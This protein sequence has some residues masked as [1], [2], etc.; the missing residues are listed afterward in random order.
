MF[1]A[2]NFP[3]PARTAM[4]RVDGS[5]QVLAIGKTSSTASIG[6][7]LRIVAALAHTQVADQARQ[8]RCLRLRQ[9]RAHQPNPQQGS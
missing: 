9:V 5:I 3:G 2:A 7:E 8:S 1:E 6:S 4:V